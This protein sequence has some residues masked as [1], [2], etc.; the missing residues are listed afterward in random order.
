MGKAS[1]RLFNTTTMLGPQSLSA[2]NSACVS[3]KARKKF[4]F[5]TFRLK[6]GQ[7]VAKPV[8]CKGILWAGVDAG[9]L[10]EL[11]MWP[12]FESVGTGADGFGPKR[13]Q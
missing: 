1:R 8:R 6:S 4:A 3:N 11:G 2:M 9:G 13:A 7:V 12:L 10:W 5:R